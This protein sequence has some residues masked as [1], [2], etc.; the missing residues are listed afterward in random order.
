MN[1][2]VS[3]WFIV[4]IP[5]IALLTNIE[6]THVQVQNP[7]LGFIDKLAATKLRSLVEISSS[8]NNITVTSYS[9]LSPN[10]L[11]IELTYSGNGISPAVNVDV[12][13]ISMDSS[14][15]TRLSDVRKDIDQS[16]NESQITQPNIT[17]AEALY[18][19]SIDQV[20]DVLS[21]IEQIG[22]TSQSATARFQW[23]PAG[24]HPGTTSI[25][26]VGNTSLS[27]AKFIE[28]KVYR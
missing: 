22:T 8:V 25:K 17:D 24:R 15:I 4:L 7:D 6:G 11:G 21:L 1:I 14:L 3:Y 20:L 19:R 16:I 28:V 27:N 18:N 10:Q 9:V 2:Q 12:S 5:V 13:A 23:T 26:L